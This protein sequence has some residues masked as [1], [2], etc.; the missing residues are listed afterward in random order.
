MAEQDR[1]LEE[2]HLEN[3][4][5]VYFV[6]QSRL[7]TGGRWLVQL[8]V[9]APLPLEADHFADDPDPAGAL[10]ECAAL[11]EGKPLEFRLLK[12]RNF[13]AEDLV[14]ET[15]DG[16]KRDFAASGLA[17]LKHPAFAANFVKKR[18]EELR[19]ERAV[20]VAHAQALKE[21]EGE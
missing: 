11:A 19:R 4:L 5:T 14:A 13:I 17:Y 9:R 1:I 16:M 6:D 21:S 20:R 7:V 2:L 3:G 15:L 10:S 12:V 18:C 8:L